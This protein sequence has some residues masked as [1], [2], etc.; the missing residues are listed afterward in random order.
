M[1]HR[2]GAMGSVRGLWD[3]AEAITPE[4]QRGRREVHVQ[5]RIGTQWFVPSRVLSLGRVGL[6]SAGLYRPSWVL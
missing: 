5:E 4:T 3:L 1:V 2:P 6:W